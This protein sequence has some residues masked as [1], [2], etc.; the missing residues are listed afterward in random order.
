LIVE[1]MLAPL[2]TPLATKR[3]P[4]PR[5]GVV[6][7]AR[8]RPAQQAAALKGQ[9]GDGVGLTVHVQRAHVRTAR[10]VD[11]HHGGVDNLVGGQ[12]FSQAQDGA[13]PGGPDL[14]VA[15]NGVDAGLVQVQFPCAHLRQAAIRIG[16]GA[17]EEQYAVAGLG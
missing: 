16:D 9:C 14:Q 5:V 13:A 8:H 12:Q 2:P 15:G 4:E 10:T 7:L 6:A 17:G 1:V 3:L 11:R